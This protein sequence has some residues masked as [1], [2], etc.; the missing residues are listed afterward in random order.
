RRKK[1]GG[2]RWV[3]EVKGIAALIAAGFALI[4]LATF[5]PTHTPA[6]QQGLTGPVGVWLGWATFQSF[7]YAGFLLPIL[8]G[9]WGASPFLRPIIVRG[10]V[11]LAGLA[12]LLVAASGLLTQATRVRSGAIGGGLVGYATAGALQGSFGDIG[13]WL[14]LIAAFPIGV[15]CVTRVSYAAV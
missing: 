2:D 7:G 9:A 8:L 3:S 5:D 6:E 15:L 12:A 11:P 1:R 10:W 14:L 4:A 13:A